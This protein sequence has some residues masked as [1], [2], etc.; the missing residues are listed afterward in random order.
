MVLEE[1]PEASYDLVNFQYS[2]YR[3]VLRVEVCRVD[4]HEA[5]HT[6]SFGPSEHFDCAK[7]VHYDGVD[8]PVLNI[9]DGALPKGNDVPI[10]YGWFHGMPRDITPELRPWADA[11]RYGEFRVDRLVVEYLVESSNEVFLEYF[12]A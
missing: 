5:Y 8:F 1:A 9:L 4:G 12:L 6:R 11:I 2:L 7:G 3:E 10:R